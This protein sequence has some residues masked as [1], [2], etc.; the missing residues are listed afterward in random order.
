VAKRYL[1][2]TADDFGIGPATS[3][4]I[5]DLAAQ[6]RVT[7]AV[8]LVNSPYAEE[9]VRAWRQAGKPL[10]LGWHPCLTLDE[11]IL[12]ARE[13]P[14]LVGTDGRLRPLGQFLRR[15]ALGLVR[16]RHIAAEFEAQYRR[17]LELVGSPPTVVN[18][19]QHVQL[20]R[21]VGDILHDI[22]RRQRPLPYVRRIRERWRMLLRVPGARLK[23]SVLSSLG[24]RDAGLQQRCG[25]PGNDWLAGITDP[26]YVA[27]PNFLVRWL[28]HIPGD[29]VEL[30]CHPG[31]DDQTLIGRDSTGSDGL[32]ERRVHELQLLRLPSYRHACARAGFELI[33]PAQLILHGR[34]TRHAA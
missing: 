29:V 21:P 13:I 16:A 3:Q 23:R 17:F 34:G 20:F 8:L 28:E 14:S 6:G 31:Y 12:P 30:A 24:R 26:P 2:V 4:G 33:A 1:V 5:L 7:C 22:L 27:D 25:F 10:E 18:T 15:W 19:H 11:P 9:S 32:V